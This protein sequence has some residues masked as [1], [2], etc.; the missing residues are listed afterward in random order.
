[1]SSVDLGEDF[2]S[3]NIQKLCLS[4]ISCF[5]NQ[6]CWVLLYT[7]LFFDH[8]SYYSVLLCFLQ[9]VFTVRV[10][11]LNTPWCLYQHSLYS[12]NNFPGLPS[13]QTSAHIRK[14][15]GVSIPV[16]HAEVTFVW[17]CVFTFSVTEGR[18]ESK[19]RRMGRHDSHLLADTVHSANPRSTVTCLPITFLTWS[20]SGEAVGERRVA[21]MKVVMLC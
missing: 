4:L 3:E 8:F 21:G 11:T 1:M 18:D 7:A 13:L 20:I 6:H 19:V 17:M 5:V 10:E 15:A 14:N 16:W 12:K 2:Q 9:D